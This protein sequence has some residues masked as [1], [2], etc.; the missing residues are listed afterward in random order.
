M[1]EKLG[2]FYN[3]FRQGQAV[4]DAAKL[5]NKQLLASA[6]AIFLATV[7][8]IG[9]QYGYDFHLSSSDLNSIAGFGAVL[10]GLFNVGATVAS[11]DKIGLPAKEPVS[12]SDPSM[13][14]IQEAVRAAQ[15]MQSEPDLGNIWLNPPQPGG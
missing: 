10:F 5:K 4:A 3:V 7:V 15:P 6:L 8:G 12:T 14:T 2:L 11:S 1:F 9:K 13:P